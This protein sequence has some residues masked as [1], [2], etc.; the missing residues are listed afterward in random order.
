VKSDRVAAFG[1]NFAAF[2]ALQMDKVEQKA[3]SCGLKK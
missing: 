2:P 1:L 3:I